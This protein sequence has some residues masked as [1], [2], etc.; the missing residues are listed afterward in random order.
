MTLDSHR[1]RCKSRRKPENTTVRARVL[2]A[3]NIELA[4]LSI[5]M[6][7]P[8]GSVHRRNTEE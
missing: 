4:A 1:N 7:E 3:L 6:K 5:A 2:R 8:T